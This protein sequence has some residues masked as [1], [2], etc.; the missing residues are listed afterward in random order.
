MLRAVVLT[1]NLR[2]GGKE[3]KSVEAQVVTEVS[4]R[5]W[6]LSWIYVSKGA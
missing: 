3:R 6:G 4:G 1:I 5:S 2:G